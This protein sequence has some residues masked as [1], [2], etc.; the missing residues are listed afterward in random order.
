MGCSLSVLLVGGQRFDGSTELTPKSEV[1]PAQSAKR[2]HGTGNPGFIQKFKP[3]PCASSSLLQP[4]H[5]R[6]TKEN[7]SLEKAMFDRTNF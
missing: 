7:V 3:N 5:S 4:Q 6:N 2:N 1:L